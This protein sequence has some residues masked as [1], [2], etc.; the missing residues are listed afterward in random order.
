MA[1]HKKKKAAPKKKKRVVKKKSMSVT[2]LFI[3]CQSA[4]TG[5]NSGGGVTNQAYTS[6]P[7]CIR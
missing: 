2:T 6:P 4:R 3:S 1:Y 5:S 7:S